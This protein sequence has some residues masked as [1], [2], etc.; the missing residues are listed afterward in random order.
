MIR[1][2]VAIL[3]AL[4][5]TPTFAQ[6][7]RVSL[8]SSV[9]LI[10]DSPITLG[11]IADIEGPQSSTIG[12]I[13][14]STIKTTDGAR[15]WTVVNATDIRTTLESD[16]RIH[17]G[18]VVI[19]GVQSSIKQRSAVQDQVTQDP[20]QPIEIKASREGPVVKD[21][22]ERWLSDRF[23]TPI[24]GLR[25]ELRD[26]DST[27]LETST[28]HRMVEVREI[29]RRGRVALRV[30]VYEGEFIVAE[31]GLTIDVT[32]QRDV[33]VASERVTRGDVLREDVCTRQLRWVSPDSSPIDPSEAIGM[34]AART[35]N[36]NQIIGTD[37]LE[38]PLDVRRGDIISARSIAGSVVVTIRGRARADA[39]RGELVELESIEGNTRF[40]VRAIA[41]GRG[42]IVKDAPTTHDKP[43]HPL[44][45]RS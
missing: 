22:I 42:V 26:H 11:D 1:V 28:L 6:A 24:D 21:H 32:I 20:V 27:F 17:A 5:T 40:T 4:L 16:K 31:R 12:S 41:P 19:V 13:P 45:D 30:I 7:T 10:Q 43:R 35:I 25:Y 2:I 8:R 34:S 33:L 38:L 14:L 15:G 29:S 36:P 23:N 9:R 37:D 39:R 44:G 3:I 18:S